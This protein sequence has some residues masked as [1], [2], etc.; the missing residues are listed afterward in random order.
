MWR[1]IFAGLTT[2][3]GPDG[4]FDPA[5]HAR[6][7]EHVVEAGVHGVIALAV[8]GEGPS[9]SNDEAQEVATTTVRTVGGRVPVLAMVGGPN[10][11]LAAGLIENLKDA[12]VDGLMV[13]PPYFYPLTPGEVGGY[14]RRTASRTSLPLMF[15]NSSYSGCPLTPEVIGELLDDIPNFVALKEGNQLQASEVI[16]RYGDRLDVFAARDVY[17]HELVAAGGAGATSFVAAVAPGAVVALFEAATAGDTR[18]ARELQGQLNALTLLL[19]RRS[20]PAGVKAA[21]DLVGLCGGPPRPPLMGY[22]G[23]ERRAVAGALRELGVAASAAVER[24]P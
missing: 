7:V 18:R 19:V 10:E 23:D 20:F 21:L 16:H 14:F 11:R 13:M 17:I 15:Y 5:G 9:Q 1:G 12:G 8:M 6:N 3:F 22:S 4:R 2:P 24:R